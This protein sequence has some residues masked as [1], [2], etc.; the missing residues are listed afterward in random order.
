MFFQPQPIVL[1]AAETCFYKD[2]DPYSGIVAE[3]IGESQAQYRPRHPERTTLYQ[4]FETHLDDYLRS[5]E[6][7]FE[8]H[9]G[10]LRAVVARSVDEFLQPS[11]RLRLTSQHRLQRIAII[12][13]KM[14]QRT[15]FGVL[16]SHKKFLPKLSIETRHPIRRKT[17]FGNPRSCSPPPLDLFDPA[18]FARPVRARTLV[19]RLALARGL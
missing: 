19:A 10:P 4:L 9:S 15:S 12:R 16:L 3:C 6:E 13:W 8:N 18:R 5:Y 11:P 7:R 2:Q 14:S 17:H 1:D